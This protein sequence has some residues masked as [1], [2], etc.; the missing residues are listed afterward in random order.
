MGCE[1]LMSD[2]VTDTVTVHVP[3]LTRELMA[4]LNPVING[5]YLDATLG[6]G[7]HTGE[8]LKRLG[9]GGGVIA[10]DRD[11]EAL[12]RA[13]IKINDPRVR[14]VHGSFSDMADKVMALGYHGIDGVIMDLGL[15]MTQMKDESRGFSFNSRES[16]DMRMDRDLPVTAGEIVNRWSERDIERILREYG[17]ERKALQIA[18][19]IVKQ[20]KRER[21]ETCLQL[22]AIVERVY[23]KRGRMHPAT[24]TFQALRIAVNDELN[25][26]SGGLSNALKILKKGGRL[27]VI[28][29]HSLE[30]R[31]VKRFILAAERE[32][33]S[34]IRLNKKPIVPV[35]DEQ[36]RNPSSRSAKLRGA[37]KL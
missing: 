17:E 29:Y 16:L 31:I 37:E 23:R 15:S 26:L 27:C 8:L 9:S 19:E 21:I 6:G 3:V 7:G 25:Q 30:D 33:G 18:R 20:R 1:G 32:E 34:L 35:R 28:T 4:L 2:T 36:R 11:E 14:Y 5:V 12:E 22:A 10:L 24:K 13:A